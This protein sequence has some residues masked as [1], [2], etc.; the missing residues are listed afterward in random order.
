AGQR[1]GSDG[2]LDG[3]M[4]ERVMIAL[5]HVL[6]LDKRTVVSGDGEAYGIGVIAAG[7]AVAGVARV[8]EIAE[9]MELGVAGGPGLSGDGATFPGP[10]VAEREHDMSG[11]ATGTRL[12]RPE[13]GARHFRRYSSTSDEHNT[14]GEADRDGGAES[15]PEFSAI[16]TGDGVQERR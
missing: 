14:F 11:A 3:S 2:I 13:I 12:G 6:D 15:R 9:S 1:T 16:R 4:A 5:D 7:E 10:E 8:A